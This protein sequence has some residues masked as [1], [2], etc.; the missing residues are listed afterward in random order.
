VGKRS[1]ERDACP[2]QGKGIVDRR[3]ALG[4]DFLV[5]EL[6]LLLVEGGC[7]QSDEASAVFETASS[8]V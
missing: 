6:G 4:G 1:A 3:H 5:E 2:D 8:T 7:G